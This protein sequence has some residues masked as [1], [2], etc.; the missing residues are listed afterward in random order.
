MVEPQPLEQD[1][2]VEWPQ[3][4]GWLL[5]VVA[6]TLIVVVLLAA[7][8]IGT[9]G[10]VPRPSRR[11]LRAWRRRTVAVLPE[12]DDRPLAI[13]VVSARA[14]L[15][16]GRPRNAIVACW[17]RLESDAAS[18]GLARLAAETP[19]E[20]VERVVAA[21]SVDPAPIGELASLYREA[22]FSR[23]ELSDDHRARA[24]AALDRVAAGLGCDVEVPV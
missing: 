6:A 2:S 10:R 23:H 18:A 14:A 9:T 12:V 20:Y 1:G 22:R 7:V 21:S 13:D 17:M 11:R 3:W 5:Q 15:Q 19:T 8:A 4:I 16:G 24:C